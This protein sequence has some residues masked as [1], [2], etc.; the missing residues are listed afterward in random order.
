MN[1]VVRTLS[2][3]II[4]GLAAGVVCAQ[5][6][7]STAFAYE[8]RLTKSDLPANG[9]FDFEFR[10]YDLPTDGTLLGTVAM[11]GVAVTDGGST[12][13]LD[14]GFHVLAGACRLQRWL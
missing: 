2:V 4:L 5:T 8:G 7:S 10:L 6:S 9:S 3:A 1:T 12:V 13:D 14:F 11:P